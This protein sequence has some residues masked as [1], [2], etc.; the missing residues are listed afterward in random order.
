MVQE[1]R[2]ILIYDGDSGLL[3]MVADVVKKTF[4]FE[5]CPLCEITY[6][7]LGKKGEWKNCEAKLPYPV[8]HKHRNEISTEWR[9]QVGKLPV[10]AFQDGERIKVLLDPPAIQVC[11]GDPRCLDAKIRER[12]FTETGQT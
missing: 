7:P 12:L 8:E 10:V 2:I 1:K 9:K 3:P 11:N 4:G 5:E 6:S